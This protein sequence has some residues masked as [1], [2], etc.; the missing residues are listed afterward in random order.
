MGIEN[1]S[2]KSRDA[3]QARSLRPEEIKSDA[4]A[5]Q[6][7]VAENLGNEV[8][9]GDLSTLSHE[10]LEAAATANWE[11][12]T[13]L[14]TERSENY[15]AFKNSNFSAKAEEEFQKL[16][17]EKDGMAPDVLSSIK[18]IEHLLSEQKGFGSDPSVLS[19]LVQDSNP[20]TTSNFGESRS[21]RL[22][23]SEVQEAVAKYHEDSKLLSERERVL[24]KRADAFLKERQARG[25]A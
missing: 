11:K 4:R 3:D 18:N 24:Q 12:D 15:K 22:F 6:G 21:L 25:L 7:A 10:E 9:D 23:S 19:V 16:S 1:S 17:S 20:S 2:F 13:E 8:G 14:T 5:I